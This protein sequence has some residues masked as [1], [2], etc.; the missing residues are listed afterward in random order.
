M[1][2]PAQAPEPMSASEEPFVYS[3]FQL[4]SPLR[5]GACAPGLREEG[6]A[7]FG[8]ESLA[9]TSLP[10]PLSEL[11]YLGQW[12]SAAGR[13]A[14]VR[15]GEGRV[16]R[17]PL[18]AFLGPDHGQLMEVGSRALRLREVTPMG[19]GVAISGSEPLARG[20][21][22]R[23]KG[24]GVIQ[25]WAFSLGFLLPSLSLAGVLESVAVEA[26]SRTP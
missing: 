21:R 14:L 10:L 25:A 19:W 18:G 24:G 22:R 12:E 8:A 23:V 5:S 11:R 7:A 4:R 9:P 17:V 16:H 15:D 6:E 3:A 20:R 2:A 26:A 13:E 1:P